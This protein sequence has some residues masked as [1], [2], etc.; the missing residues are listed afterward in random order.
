MMDAV[1][2]TPQWEWWPN[3]RRLELMDKDNTPKLRG[4]PSSR[5]YGPPPFA[6]SG[7]LWLLYRQPTGPGYAQVLSINAKGELGE[8]RYVQQALRFRSSEQAICFALA[9]DLPCGEFRIAKRPHGTFGP[10]QRYAL[11]E[12]VG[13]RAGK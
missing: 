10:L 13:R 7:G 2:R 8:S 9:A 6:V 1:E 5:T 11:R 12:L 4:A 3:D